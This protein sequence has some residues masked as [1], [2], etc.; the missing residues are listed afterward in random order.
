MRSRR[1]LALLAGG[2]AGGATVGLAVQILARWTL[3][4][5]VG[6]APPIGGARWLR[7]FRLNSQ[8]L[9]CFSQDRKIGDFV[10]GYFALHFSGF[11][12]F[13]DDQPQAGRSFSG[14]SFASVHSTISSADSDPLRPASKS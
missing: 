14:L 9:L 13:V 5:L 2:A 6:I 8:L 3:Q 7:L 10:E 1:M 4:A 12:R 11:F